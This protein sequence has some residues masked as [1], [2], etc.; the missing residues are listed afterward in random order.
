[1]RDQSAIPKSLLDIAV[2]NPDKLDELKKEAQG[3]QK[4]A[5]LYLRNIQEDRKNHKP[6]TH[7]MPSR[8]APD[9][10]RIAGTAMTTKERPSI[11]KVHR[12]PKRTAF[13]RVCPAMRHCFMIRPHFICTCS[14]AFEKYPWSRDNPARKIFRPYGIPIRWYRMYSTIGKPPA[15]KNDTAP[16]LQTSS[17]RRS[18]LRQQCCWI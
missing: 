6:Y 13:W 10:R 16:P 4:I 14:T 8:P 15:I 9:F 7:P 5:D 17:A 11:W 3:Y 1:M 18:W 2:S 12:L